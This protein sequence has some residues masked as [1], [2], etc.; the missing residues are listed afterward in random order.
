[1]NNSQEIVALLG[2]PEHIRLERETILNTL[3]ILEKAQKVLKR[4]P[5]LA[6]YSSN[7][8]SDDDD[9]VDTSKFD[10]MKDDNETYE[11]PKKMESYRPQKA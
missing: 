6:V 10:Y 4:D 3:N 11:K 8:E 1:V 5:D 9:Q 7:Y 2:E